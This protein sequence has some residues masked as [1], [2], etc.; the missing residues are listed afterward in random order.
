MQMSDL[1]DHPF[2]PENIRYESG[3]AASSEAAWLR[4]CATTEKLLGHDLD[5]ND[6]NNAGDGFSIDEAYVVF[7]LN[8]W[9]SKRYVDLV[10]SRP[11]YQQWIRDQDREF[12]DAV[13][14]PEGVEWAARQS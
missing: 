5:G 11:R 6:V 13:T 12:I 8:G 9:A 1:S 14:T 3:A 4:W 2:S 7:S 10:Q